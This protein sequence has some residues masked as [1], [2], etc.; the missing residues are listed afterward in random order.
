MT[1]QSQTNKTYKCMLCGQL[2]TFVANYDDKPFGISAFKP[3]ELCEKCY[4]QHVLNEVFTCVGC[5]DLTAKKTGMHEHFLIGHNTGILW[6]LCRRCFPKVIPL[7]N[8]QLQ[9]RGC[10]CPRCGEWSCIK[11]YKAD[12]EK[13]FPGKLK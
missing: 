12:Y 9:K 8:E 3:R 11:C 10:A 6:N 2:H 5:G 1:T 13:L 7:I 4:E